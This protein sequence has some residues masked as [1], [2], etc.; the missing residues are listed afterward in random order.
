MGADWKE[1]GKVTP[2]RNR[3]A[4]PL[5]FQAELHESKVRATGQILLCLMVPWQDRTSL[6]NIA[7]YAGQ[8]LNVEIRA[9]PE[10]EA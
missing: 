4:L 8:L 3:R 6:S 7:D 5:S 10:E 1:G 9:V 2:L